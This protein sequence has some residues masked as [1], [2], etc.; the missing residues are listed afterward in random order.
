VAWAD[1]KNE[2][3]SISYHVEHEG[4]LC[5]IIGVTPADAFDRFRPV[6]DEIIASVRRD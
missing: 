1:A 3:R 4:R 6:F 5:S 2:F